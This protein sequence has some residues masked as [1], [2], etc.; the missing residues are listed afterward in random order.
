[1]NLLKNK[2]FL[3]Y[4]GT[5]GA[6]LILGALVSDGGDPYTMVLASAVLALVVPLLILVCDRVGAD[7]PKGKNY[8]VHSMEDG[9]V[10]FRV[11]GLWIYRGEE[12]KIAWY[13]R[14]NKVY[15]FTEKEYLYRVEKGA[16]YRRGE[17]EPCMVVRGDTVYTLPDN[18][19]LYQMAE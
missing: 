5:W 13:L 6:L 16:I 9:S 11:E 14:G 18:Q 1:M 12:E 10:A 2:Y 8:T 4:L 7:A 3:Y 19:P 17:S 15:A